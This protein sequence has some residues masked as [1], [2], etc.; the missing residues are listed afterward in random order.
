MYM[1]VYSMYTPFL[2]MPRNLEEVLCRVLPHMEVPYTC[3]EAP[4]M[5]PYMC[6]APPCVH[7][8][9]LLTGCLMLYKAHCSGQFLIV[10]RI[11]LTQYHL[12][13]NTF[14]ILSVLYSVEII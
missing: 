8:R 11:S 5:F 13:V 1:Y 12:V 4:Y 14:W 6:R 10:V 7:I 9:Y 3:T 2:L